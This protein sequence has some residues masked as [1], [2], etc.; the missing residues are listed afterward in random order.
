M[1]TGIPNL[2]VVDA[3]LE[4]ENNL[5]ITSKQEQGYFNEHYSR[6]FQFFFEKKSAYILPYGD[7][8]IEFPDW[9]GDFH[10]QN[11]TDRAKEIS[12]CEYNY[13][14]SVWEK[15][16]FDSP[17]N[18]TYVH[19]VVDPHEGFPVDFSPFI[20][21]WVKPQ[22]DEQCPISPFPGLCLTIKDGFADEV[23]RS[24]GADLTTGEIFAYLEIMRFNKTADAIDYIEEMKEQGFN[25]G[26]KL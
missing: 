7:W 23:V 8:N 3:A 15:I 9:F 20:C 10:Y 16:W 1:L 14:F 5:C 17:I 6:G 11:Q 25:E 18:R 4:F 21:R 12:G 26:E 22:K 19:K 24:V 13:R 2:T